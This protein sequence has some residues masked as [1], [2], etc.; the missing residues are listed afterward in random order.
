MARSSNF[1]TP[2]KY[3]H[4]AIW[5]PTYAVVV[6]VILGTVQ[7]G[8]A[9]TLTVIVGLVACRMFLELLYRFAFGDERLTVRIGLLAVVS[10]LVV[11]AGVLGWYF[12]SSQNI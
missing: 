11:L 10:Q 4:E 3:V 6:L 1:T 8:G 2:S 7:N 9:A 12:L 5:L